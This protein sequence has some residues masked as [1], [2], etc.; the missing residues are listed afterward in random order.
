MRASRTKA[1]KNTGLFKSIPSSRHPLTALMLA[2]GL[3][4]GWSFANDI[5]LHTGSGGGT[6]TNI[7][8]TGNNTDITTATVR[9]QT[10]FNSF[11]NFTI[12]NGNTVNLH[13]PGGA[14]NLVNLVHDSRAV[15]NGTLNGLKDGKIGGNVIFADPHGFIVGSSG[16]VNVGSLTVTTPNRASMDELHRVAVV[17]GY[18]SAEDADK[19]VAELAAGKLPT[20]DLVAGGSNA[21]VIQ[22]MVNTN[23]S[24]NLHGASVLIGAAAQLQSS[25]DVAKAVFNGTVNTSGLSIGDGIADVNGGIV[26]TA[27]ENVEIAGELAALMADESGAQVKVAAR[28]SLE[29]K[30]DALISTAGQN[31]QDGG[32]VILEAP[33]ITV[34]DN[35]R[36]VTRTIG[37]GSSGDIALNALSDI[38]CTFCDED[39]EVQTLDDLKTGIQNQANPWLS[40]NLGKAQ[41]V[42]GKDAVLDAG[43]ADGTR[44]GDVTLDAFGINRQMAGYAEAGARIDMDGSILGRNVS[45]TADSRAEVTRDIIG[46]LLSKKTMKDD[47]AALASL[48]NWSEEETWAN[49]LDTL[50]DPIKAYAGTSNSNAFLAT[51]T[52]FTELTLLVP[53]LSA[54]IAKADAV[55]DIGATA[56]IN[57]SEDVNAW[58]TAQRNVSSSTWSIPVLGKKIPFG[59]DAAYG[60]ISGLTEV[61]IHAGAT[62]DVGQ[63]LTVA[64]HS[65]NSLSVTAAAE[66]S[67]DGG[68]NALKT[69]GLGFGMAMSDITTRAVVADGVNLTVGRDVNVLAL[70]EQTLENSVSFK[71]SGEGA[72]GGPAVGVSLFNSDTYAEFSADLSGARNLNV[73]AANVV[74]KQV[75]SVSVSAGASEPGY[76]DKLKAKAGEQVAKPVTDYLGNSLKDFFGMTPK[77]KDD[78]ASPTPAT[79]SKFR[80]ASAVDVTLADHSVKSVLG[81]GSAA[82]V[83]DIT[84]DL[85]VQAWQQ[86]QSLHNSAESKVNASAKREDGSTDGAEV[87]LSVA[88]VYTELDQQ[89]HAIVGDGT[90]V[91]AG[92]IGIGARFE[93]P[94]GLL[95]L[96]RWSS[97]KQVYA[98]L[99]LLSEGPQAVIGKIAT[100]YA[101][102]TGEADKLGMAGSLSILQ[103]RIDTKAWAGDNVSLT[104]T[105]TDDAEW[106]SLL[107]AVL[108]AL[109]STIALEARR[110]ALRTQGWQWSS[111]LEVVADNQLEQLAISG[112][113][114][115]LFGT[116]SGDGS[117]VGAGVNIQITDNQAIA[118]I[119][120]NGQLK[121]E[122]IKVGAF[123]DEL[124][125]AVS[126]SAGKGASVAGNGSVVVSV[127]DST[128]HASIHSSTDVTA[129]SVNLDA[130]HELGLWSAA[131]AIAA[132]EN[133]GIGAGVA[134]N[135][136]N[137]DV[138]A[139]VGDNV[140]WR[141]DYLSAGLSDNTRG[142]WLVNDLSL[143]AQSSGQSGA[144]SIAGALARS[145]QEKQEQE[146]VAATS[147]GA[148]S[149]SQEKAGSLGEVI[150]TSLTN[151]LALITGEVKDAKDKAASTGEATMDKISE[152]WGK[153]QT[154]FNGDSSSD[155]SDGTTK[156]GLSLA[157]AASASINVSAQKNR[158][159]LGNIV[160]DP[161]DADGSKVNVLSL[162]QT[163]QFSGSGAGALTLSGGDKSQHSAALSGAVAYN[164]LNNVTE[165]LLQDTLL[166]RN[167][168]LKV[169]AASGGD[170]IAMGLG[171]SVAAG[172]QNNVAVALSGSAGVFNN[173]TRAAVIDSEVEQRSAAPGTIAVNSYDRSRSLLGGGSFAFSK[174]KGGSAGGSMVLAIM[175][176][177]LE[178]EWL[179]SSATDFDNLEVKANSASRVLAGALA[180]AASTG[181]QSGAGA[182]SLFV[183]LMNNV[184]KASVDKTGKAD[185][186]LAGGNVTVAA[187]SVPGG[188]ALNNIFNFDASADSTLSETGLDMT[189]TNATA[190]I[191]VEAETNDELFSED[192]L[193]TNTGESS[194]TADT[195]THNL[196][197]SGEIAGEAVLAIAGSVAGTSGQAAVGGAIG[198]VYNGSDYSASVAH[199]DIDLTGDL[200]IIARNETD[201]L[202]GTIGAAVGS[203]VAI[204]GSAT[205][206]IG[207]GKVSADL[208]MTGRTLKADDLTVQALKTGG[209]YSLAGSISGS[210]SSAAVGAAFSINDMQQSATAQVNGGTYEL[211]GDATL[212]AAQQSRIITAALSGAISGSGT[213]VGAA[214]TYNRIADTTTA[215]LASA[216]MSAHNLSISASQPNLGASIWS[217]AFNLAAGGGAAGVGA[218]VAVNLID[219][220]REAKLTDST[221]NLSGDASLV[222]ALDGEIW[223][224]GIDAAGGGNAGVGGSFAANNINGKDEVSISGS[225]VNATGNDQTLTLDA[226]AGAGLTIASLAGSVT[227]GGTAAVGL[228][229][230]VNRIAADRSALIQGGSLIDGF[231][232][233]SL[234]SG[235]QQAIYSIAVAGGGAGS[236]AVNGATTTNILDGEERAEV[237]S[238]EVKNV[239][240][241]SLSAA[242]GSRTIWGLGAVINGAGGTAVGAANVNNIIL[243]KR[244]AKIDKSLVTLTGPLNVV[245][246][247][248]ALI[249]SAALGGGGAG[250]AAAG[251]SIAVNVVDGE[252][253]ASIEESEIRG[254]TELTVEVTKGEVDI[255]TLAGNVQGAGSGAGAGAV[256]VSTVSQIRQ[257]WI[258][259]SSLNLAV[260]A[261]AR[262]EALTQANIDTLALSG[263]A[264]GSAA[265][266]F[267]NTSNNID[268]R[269]YARVLNSGGDADSML[270][271][272]RDAS[273][274]N[275]L[276]GGI[277]AA[278]SV[279]AGVATAVNRIHNDI[280][281]RVTGRHVDGGF[282]LN[283]LAVTAQSDA[284]I[285]TI[286]V[287]GGF[288]GTAAVSGGISTS[289]LDTS[290]RA[291]I[292]GGAGVLAQNNV[293]VTAFNNDII[294]SYAGVVA[295]SGNAAVSGLLT[296]NVL[297]SETEAAIRD[298]ATE[299]TALALGASVSVDN[300]EVENAPDPDAWADAEQFNP[301][302]DLKTG[303]E[304][305]KGV[306][307]RATSLQQAGQV[308]VSAAVSLVPLTSASVGGVSNTQVLG[309]STLASIDQAQINQSNSGAGADQQVS[310]GAASHSYSFGGVLNAAL[311]LGAAAVA[312][313][314]DTGVISRDV[315]ARVRGA[316]VTSRGAMDVD[317]SATNSASNIVVSASGAIVGI[318]GSAAVLV[319]EG[320]TEA[321]VDGGSNLSVGSL[322]ISANAINSLAPSADTAT[323]GAVGAGAG[324]AVGYNRSTVRA[325]LGAQADS[326]EGRTSVTS[327]GAVNVEA[328]SLTRIFGN[329]LSVSGGGTAMAGSVNVLIVEN[330]TEAGAGKLDLGTSAKR[331]ASLKIDAHDKLIALSNAG[332]AAVGSFSLGAS[333]NVLVANNATRA[334]L[335][336]SQ[337]YTSGAVQVGAARDVDVELY[338]VTGGVG[339]NAALG[340]SVGLLMLGSGATAVEG[341]DPLDELNQNGSGTLSMVDGFTSRDTQD[342]QYDT[343][344]Y[345]S[346]TGQYVVERR[347]NSAE[348]SLVNQ[349]GQIGSSAD[350]LKA[351]TTYTH[352]TLARIKGGRVDSLGNVKVS[353]IDSL[354]TRN[355]SGS[356]Q[357]GA[358]AAVG[359]AVSYTLS[360]ARV[361]AD[362][363]ATV[364]AESLLTTA[365][366]KALKDEPAV[367]VE[368][369]TGAAGFGAG[370]GAAVSVA[371]MNNIVSVKLAGDQRYNSSLNASAAD[372]LGLSVTADGAAFGAVAAGLVIGTGLRDSDVGVSVAADSKLS[373]NGINLSA[374]GA[375]ALEVTTVGA[376]GGLALAGTAVAALGIDSTRVTAEVGD[377]TILDGG[378]NGVSVQ[379]SAAPQIDVSA[380]GVSVSGGAGVGA[381]YARAQ[382]STKVTAKLGN[383]VDVKGTGG[384]KILAKLD[385]Q[386]TGPEVDP[387]EAAVR[388][389]SMAGTGGL[390]FSANGSVAEAI[391]SS[392]VRAITGTDLKLPSGRV[393]IDAQSHTQQY[394]EA[395]G[396]AVGGLAVGA[397]VAE[398]RSTTTTEAILGDRANDRDGASLITDL[399]VSADGEDINQAKSIA[400]SG[401]LISGNA[402]IARTRTSGNVLAEIGE[403]VDIAASSLALT[404]K[405]NALYG[406]HA[407]SVNA[408][409]IGGSGAGSDNEV[410]VSTTARIS[411]DAELYLL[412]DVLL[413]A[414]SNIYTRHMGEAA[415]GAGGGVISGQAVFNQ[416]DVIADSQVDIG[417]RSILVAG[418]AGGDYD[419]KLIARAYTR[420]EASEDVTLS[421]GGAIAGGG[422]N[423]VHNATFTNTVKVG[424]DAYL[425][426]YGQIGLG[427][428]TLSSTAIEALVS[429]WGAAGVGTA[430][431]QANISSLQSVSV[432]DGATLAALGNI[433]LS[434]GRDPEGLWQTRINADSVAHSVVRG[435]I[436]VPDARADSNINNAASVTVEQNASVLAARNIT[437]GGYNGITSALADGE[438]R[439]YQ[440][441][442][443]P[444]T[445]RNSHT[446]EVRDS[447]VQLDGDF[448]AGR[449]NELII[450]IAA[451]GTITQSAGLPTAALSIPNF[452]PADFLNSYP[453]MDPITKQ[454]LLSTISSTATGSIELGSLLAAGGNITVNADRL[455]GSGNLTANGGA[456]I[457]ITNR[458]SKYL[459]LGDAL[460]PD[461]PGGHVLFTGGAGRSQ[462]T[463]DLINEVNADRRAEVRI[464]NSYAGYSGN[465]SYGPAIFLTGD[466][467]N[468]GGLV[469]ISNAKGS[470][471][472]FGST[473][474][475]QVLVEVPEGSMSV[476]QPN[477][478]WA[479]G[480]NPLSEWKS[481]AGVTGSANTAIELIANYVYGPVGIL[482]NNQG[483]L[484]RPGASGQSG[485]SDILFGGC[486]PASLSSGSNCSQSTAQSYTGSAWQFRGIDNAASW[487]P[488]I[489][490]RSLHKSTTTYNAADLTGSA[491]SKQIVGGQVGIQARY[492][493]INGTI[494]SGQATSRSLTVSSSLDS[495]LANHYCATSTCVSAVDIPLQYLSATGGSALVLAKYDFVNQRILVDDVNASGGG[496]VYMKGAIISTNPLGR[497]EVN[498]GYGQVTINN[499]SQAKLELGNI[500]T[501]AGSVGIVQIVDTLKDRVNGELAS[502]WYVH[503]QGS[504]LSVFDNRNGGSSI[505]SAYLVSSS[506]ASSATYTPDA[507]VRYRWS[508][509][510]SLK[511]EVSSDADSF[512]VSDWAWNYP[513]G[514]PNDPWN[515]GS[516]SLYYGNGT[517]GVYEQDISGS[518]GDFYR[519][520]V[521]YHGCDSGIGS[522]CHWDFKASGQYA[523]GDSAGQYYAQ[524]GYNFAR[525][526][527]LTVSHSVKA[528]NPFQIAFIGN[529]TGLIDATTTNDLYVGGRLNN[530][531]GSTVLAAGGNIVGMPEANSYSLHLT[532]TAAGEVGNA[533][534]PFAASLAPGGTLSVLSGSAGVNLDI[535]SDVII[536][537]VDAGNGSGDVVISASGNLLGSN[538]VAATTPHV[539]GR[540]ITLSSV[541]GGIG[542]SGKA[543][544]VHGKEVATANGGT[545]HGVLNAFANRDIYLHETE[546]DS[547]V[548]SIRSETGD[549]W[550]RV[551]SGS[552]YDAGRRL[553]SDTLDESQRQSV[554][555]KL[556]L[557]EAYGAEDNIYATS[558]K[559]FQDMVDASYREYWQLKALGSVAGSDFVLD[560]A[561]LA[562]IRP[563]AELRLGASGVTD[564]QVKQFVSERFAELESFFASNIDADWRTRS[565]FQS[566]DALFAYSAS[567]VQV[568]ALTNDAIWTAGEL[569]YAIDQ[570]ALGPSSGTSV[571]SAEPNL[572]GR[573]VNIQVAGDVGQ[574]ADALEINLADLK[575]GNL[576][577]Q[578]AAALAVANAPGDVVLNRNASGEV[579]SLSVSRTSP[580]YVE[581]SERFDADVDGSLYLQSAGDLKVGVVNALKNARL[582]AAN[583]ILAAQGAGSGQFGIGQD[584]TLLAGTGS[585]GTDDSEQTMLTLNVGGRLLA[586]SAGQDIAL[587]WANGDFRIGQVFAVGDIHLNALDGSLLGQFDQLSVSGRNIHLL[588]KDD[589]RG[590]NGALEVELESTAA[591]E[592][593]GL[594][595]GDVLLNSDKSLSVGEFSAD[596]LLSISS[597]ADLTARKLRS[598]ADMQLDAKGKVELKLAEATGKLLINSLDAVSLADSA[599]AGGNL[600]VIASSLDM[601]DGSR[602]SAG[603]TL[604]LTTIGDMRLGLLDNTGT[605]ATQFLVKAGG[606]LLGNGDGQVNL[607]GTHAGIAELEAGLGI[608]TGVTPLLVNLPKLTK[609]EAV[610]GDI[611]L[612]HQNDLR[613]DE[614]LAQRGRA[615]LGNDGGLLSA[616]SLDAYQSLSVV[617]GSL[618]ADK[619]WARTDDLNLN[620]IEDLDVTELNAAARLDV[621]VGRN[622]RLGTAEVQGLSDVKVAGDLQLDTLHAHSNTVLSLGSGSSLGL[623]D[624]TGDLSL[625]VDG[626]LNLTRADVTG[627]AQLQHRGV[628]GTQL[629]YGTLNVGG[630]LAVTGAGDWVGGQAKVQNDVVFDVGSANLGSVESAT[631]SLSLQSEGLFAA[632][633]LTSQQQWVELQAGSALL[634][635]VL[636]ATTL[637]VNT[638]G[639]LTIANGRSGGNLTLT[640]EPG[641]TGTIRFGELADP[642]AVDVLVPAHLYSGADILVQT[643]GDVFGGNAE[644]VG[645]VRMLGRNLFFGRV[646]SLGTDVFLQATGDADQGDGNIT[647]LMAEAARDVSILANGNL[648]MPKVRYGGTYSLKAGRDLTLGIGQDLSLG[649]S[650]EAGR[651]L[652]F[653]VGGS[654]DLAN[655]TAGR[656]ISIT[657]GEYIN[658]LDSVTAGGNIVLDAANGGITVGNGIISTGLPY[659]GE[660]LTG[661]ILLTATGDIRASTVSSALNNVRA[662]G[663]HLSFGNL[664]AKQ[665][666]NLFALG[667]I[668]VG[669]SVSG[670]DQF[671]SAD[672]DISFQRLLAD[673]QV[674]LDSLLDTRGGQLVADHGLV[675]NAGW[676]GGVASPAVI[677]LQQVV[678]PTMSL[679]AG[680]A[681]DVADAQLG[682]S[683]DLHAQ[684]IQM[685]GEHTGLGSLQLLVEGLNNSGAAGDRFVTRLQAKAVR[686]SLL[687]M[688]YSDFE[689]S[690]SIADFEDIR[691]A[692]F[693]RLSTPQTLLIADNLSP[694]YR[695]DAHVQL[696]ELD[697]AFWLY[698]ADVTSYTNAYVLHRDAT[699]LVRVP[700]FAEGHEDGGVD[701]QG[702]TA[703]RYAQ[704]MLAPDVMSLRLGNLLNQAAG[705]PSAPSTEVQI[706]GVMG[707]V[708]LQWPQGSSDNTDEKELWD[709]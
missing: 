523:S 109:D 351:G 455:S 703:A 226:S 659:Q 478:Y 575:N 422:V 535:G 171:L 562:F 156:K 378:A 604:A 230:S 403:A 584:L 189:G 443:I 70:T 102:S 219:A 207:R 184:V 420:H 345:D 111:P 590:A 425:S 517:E 96:D 656:H 410:T 651:D 461:E 46:M 349:S 624:V 586:A 507:N 621:L 352:E 58:A 201:V 66:N 360:N 354:A 126:P 166:R 357:L 471:G 600:T 679:W 321:L 185:S 509:Q 486:L 671:W 625:G 261:D 686:T 133:V 406:T 29:L 597:E 104:A 591:G 269:T 129:D 361:T 620:L 78:T 45:I 91:S 23:G 59:F 241:L 675:A 563:L 499:L 412:R 255:K 213:G 495:W 40:A 380:T 116:T 209:F 148:D 680:S 208:D 555:E 662:D 62:L 699:H 237:L 701:Y 344:V 353:A 496:F 68:G 579:V 64:A 592:V 85:V 333:A 191:E 399:L 631:S 531:G 421:T 512:Y 500:D 80:L 588:A 502:S 388:A 391:N 435:I 69:M 89:T 614:L 285:N 302:L 629:E 416:S 123:Q 655:V 225:T 231:A 606:L 181:Q 283:D 648:L 214:M 299:V 411:D 428:Y 433:D 466:I 371:E 395:T 112:N 658:V 442:F 294:N 300:G 113:F 63:D 35:A 49:I 330:V 638:K 324:V 506:S 670:G 429:T 437:V 498:N 436:A 487:I 1:K 254:A 355:F 640:A 77:A 90:Q 426:A 315:T 301:S 30:G 100:Q 468:L 413:S 439:G 337:V 347:S 221:V 520:R 278:G 440:L 526:A 266:V 375:G 384:L 617:G 650:A 548:G 578:Q 67:V 431:A 110:E 401:G 259:D 151:G 622:A 559:P 367:K 510:A 163:H 519:F 83:I 73:N 117:A 61:A 287:S 322:D 366:S 122:S 553:A 434:A 533:G 43:H 232:D 489:G 484:I 644:A 449:Y 534:S 405:F 307:V 459:L 262:I 94:I 427:T 546:G 379:A 284:E 250:S 463:S 368:S 632:Q 475:Q 319:L 616:G 32:D 265:A 639:D 33:S 557:T 529:A 706:P 480:S 11:G 277:A 192:G 472:Q 567:A 239:G 692:D 101:N 217:L 141:P 695:S 99:K 182:G 134:V 415:T 583:G 325:W 653:V 683:A 637:K 698:Q 359:A 25:T 444:I 708:N 340:G 493:D 423:N 135:V 296:V 605:A 13:V 544:R 298:A 44:A 206:L 705:Y 432:A 8:V 627:D 79:E 469:H 677:Q 476:F 167:D 229:A 120:A 536:K 216:L 55:V 114:D 19:Y 293:A 312:V 709:I 654:V 504:G 75:T 537:Q 267:S 146:A 327:D 88:A 538:A 152:Y 404:A 465:V 369:Y 103:N 3:L 82:P 335:L 97:L 180:V 10:G 127:V 494:S 21:I 457:Q 105:S 462:F 54:Y 280:E 336:D 571:G 374:Q 609:V 137:T 331:A 574:L 314:A 224:I 458:S 272:A 194:S 394:A 672:E 173:Q 451:D 681:I 17:D 400:G 193:D 177:Q 688:V 168:L 396:I 596:G 5:T 381:S 339:G 153:L 385:N 408:A 646:Q 474:G 37:L 386:R 694:A 541:S 470:L 72:S 513:S 661:D 27:T 554:W 281:A 593:S 643:E 2:S 313:T 613:I 186:S 12:D 505:S 398:A 453:G 158:A 372:S 602:F 685:V 516:G 693:L 172:G 290:A 41:I 581:A 488:T 702:I 87:S 310:V 282:A 131:G 190:Q 240:S 393:E 607:R 36:V 42:I 143:S 417:E 674:L 128:V 346:A 71:A 482:A 222:S 511:R 50:S 696:H 175:G 176:N 228:A 445:S 573:N 118:G 107:A 130:Q 585:L 668:V 169:Q 297:Q 147:G 178:A 430:N 664:F 7:A 16:V 350:R 197:D 619:I 647:G 477:G 447:Y 235:V 556:S 320:S 138:Y 56:N 273:S 525:S 689:T 318:A 51:P 645:E 160:L 195:S 543:L 84:G 328:H 15:I 174:D 304:L 251:A 666:V 14:A 448:L 676:R 550:L 260:G 308:S 547:W 362:V 503:T 243:A 608:G 652:T 270:V 565:A 292:N 390:Y 323:G 568:D 663:H 258:S 518:V 218:G 274:I 601:A 414:N 132:S 233:A 212:N 26:I 485:S 289:I 342:T 481:F 47:I 95:G 363:D 65:D 446:N 145:E 364:V 162:N 598:G 227:G 561:N 515:V 125:I 611:F 552:L 657:S 140:G 700:N 249:R 464:D 286:S 108:P 491:A 532:M 121:A 626:L 527:Q 257:A 387:D 630:N 247:G 669:D 545:E 407:N 263:A 238:S 521:N 660:S 291:L 549:V 244:L 159:H 392:S 618:S 119:G 295:G 634:G 198:V 667:S 418:L 303:S 199:T 542:E 39:A 48:N 687:D 402:T 356:L 572:Y 528:D 329:S 610:T 341:T 690:A 530:P 136:V 196:F 18:A 570:T 641:F 642:D 697:K 501:G 316:K 31:S 594:A 389:R 377:R 248:D 200:G 242:E 334:M 155:G 326:L 276:S 93:Q 165:A 115:A 81:G 419:G 635:N 144:F 452:V 691:N 558:V 211:T 508:Q 483:L 409:V 490:L 275:S 188:D 373:A 76:L 20:A 246:G 456:K 576:S 633:S 376:A 34:T 589:I 707:P 473:Y 236:V 580:F 288:S 264:A 569:L 539:R 202:A 187:A 223:S 582:A 370:I 234:K 424:E 38:S 551:Q 210:G 560:D 332:S 215:E 479:V 649:G 9:G 86:Q 438:A 161:R 343:V 305:I 253:S 522:N 497:I 678:T 311:S 599:T 595:G 142:S 256:A 673:G 704:A 279:A 205:A 204:A 450:D 636:A 28:R 524:W 149:G 623:L 358:T 514:Q 271:K 179:G 170:Q 397:S 157:A 92:R 203:K 317:A 245:S 603:G 24:I 106:S 612:Q 57:A 382:S 383:A 220:E 154:A 4:P 60:Q 615:L 22:G 365:Q 492:I 628:A 268:A 577:V 467:Y 338:T 566:Y 682:I 454:I 164:Q 53:N 74:Y 252:E 540:N 684:D 52:N 665:D 183:V 139:L 348:T 6:A 441:G 306:A 564:A 309:G 124:I 150:K 587:R 98:N 460:I